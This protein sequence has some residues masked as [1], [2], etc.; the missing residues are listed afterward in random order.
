MHTTRRK[1][2]IGIVITSVACVVFVA[3]LVRSIAYSPEAEIPLPSAHIQFGSTTPQVP[4]G[5]LS[6]STTPV[7]PTADDYPIRLI[8][9]SIDVDT[10]VQRVG[11]AKSG[12][13]SPPNNFTDVGWYKYGT[14][15]GYKGS[16]VMAGHVDNAL[17][18]AG[19]FKHLDEVEKGDEV[20]V[21][22]EGGKTLRF[23]VVS[24]N[25]YNY[26]N[27][28]TE[29][30]FNQND[31]ARLR[32]I[33]CGGKWVQSDKSYDTRVVVTAELIQ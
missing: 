30:I 28:P 17:A 31:K 22:T 20:Q 5:G 19:V 12:N 9:P 27:V 18:L 15:P 6:V 24:V 4:G 8:I 11:I 25:T 10:K 13:M 29:V 14:V 16:A 21:R 7:V 2:L 33:T 3:T 23:V 26:R 1:F 32:L